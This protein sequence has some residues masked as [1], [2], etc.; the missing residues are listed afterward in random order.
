MAVEFDVLFSSGLGKNRGGTEVALPSTDT[1]NP[2]ASSHSVVT[3]PGAVL[4]PV[5][6]P[7]L[8]HG[9]SLLLARRR[10]KRARPPEGG[11]T[12]AP[13]RGGSAISEHDRRPRP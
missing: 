10:R 8:I 1:T 4:D 7:S 3:E 9:V 11:E 5:H 6:A 12:V 13:P 2:V